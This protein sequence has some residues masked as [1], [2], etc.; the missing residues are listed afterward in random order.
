MNATKSERSAPVGGQNRLWTRGGAAAGLLSIIMTTV[1]FVL[2]GNLPMTQ[3]GTDVAK[4]AAQTNDATFSTGIYIELLGYL[5]FLI[6]GAW[7]WSIV[8]RKS[9]GLDWLSMAGLV[10][11]GL[12]IGAS[13]IDDGIWLA[14]LQSVRQGSEPQTLAFVRDAAEQVFA[15]SFMFLGLFGIL[16]GSVSLLARSLPVWM[17]ATAVALGVGTLVPPVALIASLIFELWV[18]AVCLFVLVRP[19]SARRE[20][21]AMALAKKAA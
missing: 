6:F 13:S 1:G 2:H 3:T 7:I 17:G 12:F 20:D 9:N 11:V 18:V 15:I 4:W 8:Y 19:A 21:V 16:I 10:A 5:V 14:L